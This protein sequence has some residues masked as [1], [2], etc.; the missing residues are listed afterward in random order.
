[1]RCSSLDYSFRRSDVLYSY[2]LCGCLRMF[3]LRAR[4]RANL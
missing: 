1:M 3:N 4:Y 2:L